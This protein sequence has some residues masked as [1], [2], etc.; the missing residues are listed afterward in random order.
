MQE[1]CTNHRDNAYHKFQNENPSGKN[2]C[3]R[4]Q[5]DETENIDGV[6]SGD[7]IKKV[8]DDQNDA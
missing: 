2:C 6:E 7:H 8:Q 1:I 5:L 4:I 3:E